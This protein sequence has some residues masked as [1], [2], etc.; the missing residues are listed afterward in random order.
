MFS[1]YITPNMN[2]MQNMNNL[3]NPIPSKIKILYD[4]LLVKKGVPQRQSALLQRFFNCMA[5]AQLT[6]WP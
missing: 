5:F 2:V 6:Y 1:I 3:M 4:A